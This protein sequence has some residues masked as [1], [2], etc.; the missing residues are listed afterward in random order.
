MQVVLSLSQTSRMLNTTEKFQLEHP[1]KLSKL[2]MILDHLTCGSHQAA[3]LVFLAYHTPDSIVQNL[4]P[5]KRTELHLIFNTDPDLLKE[6]VDKML[7]KL[8]VFLLK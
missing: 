4:V 6:N 5:T 1:D 7:L 2:F 8:V 3:A